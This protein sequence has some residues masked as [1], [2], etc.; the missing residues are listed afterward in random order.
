MPHIHLK[1]L[2]L[3][4]KDFEKKTQEM[5]EQTSCYFQNGKE[6]RLTVAIQRHSSRWQQI[7]EDNGGESDNVVQ[8]GAEESDSCSGGVIQQRNG[9]AFGR[10]MKF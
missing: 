2:S 3:G 4:I 6:R 8:F 5:R 10:D 9:K 7:R 1:I